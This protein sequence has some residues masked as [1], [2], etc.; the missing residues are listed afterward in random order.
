MVTKTEL[1]VQAF[2]AGDT[3]KALK[4]ASGFKLGITKQQSTV[5]KRGY[6]CLHYPDTYRQ[7]GKDPA[8]CVA[9]ATALF[10]QLFV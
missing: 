8:A 3:A 5:L 1:A 7:L 10:N 4:L 6:E 9:E 2:H